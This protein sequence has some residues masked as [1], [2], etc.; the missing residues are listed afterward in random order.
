MAT[1]EDVV[2]R[3]FLDATGLAQGQ[4][5]AVA[6]TEKS[7]ADLAASA[8]KGEKAQ[9][10]AHKRTTS[11]VEKM[12]GAIVA[13]NKKAPESF[14]R[15]LRVG[16]TLLSVFAGA[17]S[18]EEFTR[19]V[20]SLDAALGRLGHNI[21][22]TPDTLSS[23][24]QAAQRMGGSFDG[25]VNGMKSL[26]DAFQDLR[27]T[28]TNGIMEP[29][30]RLQALSGKPI[31]FGKDVHQNFLSIAEAMKAVDAKDPALADRLGRQILGGDE[32]LVNLAKLG[33]SGVLAQEKDSRRHGVIDPKDAAAAQKL[34][35]S[36]E[37]L[38]QS[39]TD[40][41]RKIVTAVAP[42]LS[43]LVTWLDDIIDRNKGW[44]ATRIGEYIQTFVDYVKSHKSD[45]EDFG[46]AIVALAAA[47]AGVVAAVSGQ[48]PLAVAFEA[49]G[50]LLA[51]RIL[52]PLTS[53][54]S[55]MR[56]IGGLPLTGA[57][58]LL[59]NP[60]VAGAG[61]ILA[62]GAAAGAMNAGHTD[63][64]GRDAGTWGGDAPGADNGGAHLRHRKARTPEGIGTRLLNWTKGVV[65]IVP[66]AHGYGA[67][68]APYR[69]PVDKKGEGGTLAP[70][71]LFNYLK[72]KG[73]TDNAAT[74]LTGA[75]G[76][77]SSFNPNAVHDG[78]RGHGL[79]GHNDA[80]IDMRGKNWQQQADLALGEVNRQ[81]ADRV[82]AAKTPQELADAE[83]HYERP[84]GYSSRDPRG[85]DNYMG[86]F[87]T[88]E[89]FGQ[90][91]GTMKPSDTP[92]TETPQAGP[93]G[94]DA[95]QAPQSATGQKGVYP[96]W[97]DERSRREMA[98]VN[99]PLARDLLAA[100]EATGQ[101]FKVAQGMRTPEEAAGNAA[102]GRGVRNSQHLYGAAAD[103]HILDDKGNVTY[104]RAA[105][106]KF[107]D[108]F[109]DHSRKSGGNSRWLGNAGGRWA[110][111][112]VHFDQGLGYGQ[113][114]ARDP[115]GEGGPTKADV[116]ASRQDAYKSPDNPFA[117]AA[118]AINPVSPAE[119]KEAPYHPPIQDDR[120]TRAR[121]AAPV[122][123]VPK[124]VPVPS[125][126]GENDR[127]T[128]AQTPAP[129]PTPKPESA[130]FPGDAGQDYRARGGSQYGVPHVESAGDTHRP[131]VT[132]TLGGTRM[133]PAGRMLTIDD[134][135]NHVLKTMKGA[136][137]N[138]RPIK[139]DLTDGSATKIGVAGKSGIDMLIARHSGA[140]RSHVGAELKKSGAEMDR[141]FGKAWTGL[142]HHAGIGAGER[143]WAAVN[144]AHHQTTTHVDNST[145][146]KVG[147]INV[148]TAATDAKGI[149]ADIEPHLARGQAAG[150][151]NYGLA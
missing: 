90:E 76:S 69:A 59:T 39:V 73:A 116:T 132:S 67:T 4:K 94:A 44:I 89:R 40:F 84:R 95:P 58:S 99:A 124:P 41:G 82:N 127:E 54:L 60:L 119:A 139:V 12:A 117:R 1:F 93:K 88:L 134:A 143:A 11:S 25:A 35:S 138:G 57:L 96:E 47:F 133:L 151:G 78:G 38:T 14:E 115:Y 141:A 87:H 71:E 86:R 61:A 9:V 30:A 100:S 50:A 34:Q 21:G 81:Y 103:I 19:K 63:E 149:A 80:R 72:S 111:D 48:S 36:F 101:K 16:L 123:T 23:I 18:V 125:P 130:P 120:S 112:I 22:Q 104:D 146:T 17:K 31:T 10:D 64:Y 77:E 3:L 15:V 70:R 128:R 142:G 109:Q 37:S 91:F 55:T 79:W 108:A 45:I 98:G 74:M 7:A 137:D 107:A 68:D 26:S 42:A 105:Y 49:F 53:I 126:V 135:A 32:S 85:G 102:S 118:R 75:A 62:G 33:R 136:N 65:G 145:A 83:M 106:Q 43:D 92:R 52:A 97:M 121:R 150:R 8:T 13:S 5:D 122:E 140:L 28:G 144:H 6:S 27:T 148:H 114:R 24:G 113:S 110:S 46:R 147:T 131:E 129:I 51:L 29:L 2:V 56:L 66:G 20:V